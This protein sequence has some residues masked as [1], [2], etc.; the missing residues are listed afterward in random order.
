VTDLRGFEWRVWWIPQVPMQSFEVDVPDLPT[1]QLMVDTLAKYDLF[2]YE[3]RIKPDY[4]NTGGV[5]YRHT[6]VTGGE[7]EDLDVDDEQDVEDWHL[8]VE[9]QTELIHTIEEEPV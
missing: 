5:Q 9:S 3:H 4:S 7:W 6:S 8:H 2:Q 1:A